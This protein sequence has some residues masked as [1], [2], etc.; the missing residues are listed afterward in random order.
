REGLDTSTATVQWVVSGYALAFGLTLVTGGRLGDA[1][2]RRRMMVIGLS[3]FILA[4]AAVG[5]APS[6]GWVVVGRLVQGASAGLLTPQNSGLIQQLFRGPERG[7][8]FGLFGLVV[9]ISSAAGPVLGGLIIAGAGAEHG[10]RYIFLVNIPIGLVAMVAVIRMVPGRPRESREVGVRLDLPGAVLL[11]AAVL[12]VLLPTVA[13]ESGAR[14]PMLLLLAAG[15]LA[16]LFVR[17]ESGLV[18]RGGAPLLD[19]GLLRRTP[20]YAN[21]VAVGTLYFTGFTGF[22]LVLSVYYQEQ[23]G[24]SALQTGLLISPFA[25]GSAITAP[26]AGRVVSRLHRK[27]TVLALAVTMVGILATAVLVPMAGAE[28]LWVV[29]VPAMFLAGIGGGGVVSPNMTLSLEEV[30]PRMGG[31]AGGALQTGQ[32]MG[33]AIGA[34]LA[35]TIYQLVLTSAGSG[36]GLR[37]ALATG[38]ALLAASLAMAVRAHRQQT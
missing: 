13:A 3:G 32:R 16:W 21:G 30:P 4:S 9:S 27:V 10:W 31:A 1:Y 20:G 6:A 25:V 14:L 34:A 26:L 2:G 22:F 7:R 5:L 36:A 33:S 23:L 15:P 18:R 35:M 17:R 8:A 19:V 11:G 28:R 38:L 29:A 37:A 24:L 12:C